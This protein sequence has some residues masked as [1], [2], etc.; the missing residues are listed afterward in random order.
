MIT[1]SAFPMP[2]R[3]LISDDPAERERLAQFAVQQADGARRAVAVLEPLWRKARSDEDRVRALEAAHAT[4]VGWRYELAAAGAVKHV[5][6]R[7]IGPERFLL[8][9]TDASMNWDRLTPTAADGDGTPGH[10]TMLAVEQ[11][12]RRQFGTWHA[13]DTVHNVVVIDGVPFVGTTLVRGLAARDVADMMTRRLNARGITDIDFGQ[14]P[15]F[16]RV[17]NDANRARFFHEALKLL[18][19]LD[20]FGTLH[21]DRWYQALYLL[22]L[23]PKYKRGG[24]AVCRTFAVAVAE[25]AL[26]GDVPPFSHD[27][28]F[29]AFVLPQHQFLIEQGHSLL[30]R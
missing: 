12:A 23:S 16:S 7:V 22:L 29:R 27:V 10:Q 6:G 2:Q 8:P 18:S 30:D 3:V 25:V 15:M 26:C 4:V 28:D 9:L 13:R 17:P 19:R 24:D 21:R 5:R 1:A 20:G 11:M 14:D